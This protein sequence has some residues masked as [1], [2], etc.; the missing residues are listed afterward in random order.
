MDQDK[1]G[2]RKMTEEL[3]KKAEEYLRKLNSVGITIYNHCNIE[4]AYKDG[5]EQAANTLSKE[6]EGLKEWKHYAND[7][8]NELQKDKEHLQTVI[9]QRNKKIKEL[10]EFDKAQSAKLLK[11]V[12]YLKSII[13]ALLN[14]ADEY[15][16][17]R[18]LEIIENE[19]K[20]HPTKEQW[21][22]IKEETK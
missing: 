20:M 3:E 11:E 19:A 17:Q 7:W 5:Y 14:K 8:L 15:A 16:E 10:N 9:E 4:K 18:A 12:A 1:R 6:I 2:K 22:K 13:K 21:Q